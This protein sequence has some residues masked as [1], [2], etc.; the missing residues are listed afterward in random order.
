MK[1]VNN[2]SSKKQL[3]KIMAKIDEVLQAVS[4]LQAQVNTTQDAITAAIAALND[5]IANGATPAQLQAVIDGLTA[6]KTDVAGTA[7]DGSA[8]A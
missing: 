5:Q 4:D 2:Y 6:V 1:I 8:S 3:K 7:L